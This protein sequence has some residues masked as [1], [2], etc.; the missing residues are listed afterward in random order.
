MMP[1]G[2]RWAPLPLRLVIGFGF[3][4]HGLPKL[5]TSAGH[6]GF[7][8]GLRGMGIPLPELMAWVAGGVEVLGGLALILG[9]FVTI[10]T[11]LL[12][13]HQ[14]VALV[15]VHFAAG[16]SFMH[17]TG[18][19]PSGP[20]FGLPGYEVNLLYIASLLALLLGGAGVYSVDMA[21]AN[22]REAI[23]PQV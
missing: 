21:R 3:I 9:A 19:T 7:A 16:F 12:L 4:Y 10:A 18:M 22:R 23:G 11:A 15:K 5:F 13:L 8:A 1:G 14:L 20:Q 2:M 17:I 6:V